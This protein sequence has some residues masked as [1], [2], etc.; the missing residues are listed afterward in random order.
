VVAKLKRFLGYDDD[1]VAI[2]ILGAAWATETIFNPPAP[3][4]QP[5]APYLDEARGLYAKIAQ[6][7][8]SLVSRV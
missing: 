7:D 3:W 4:E 8:P 5:A 6:G 1:E 2:A